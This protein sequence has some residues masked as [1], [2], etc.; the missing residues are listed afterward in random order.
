MLS[1]STTSVLVLGYCHNAL[2]MRNFQCI[3][4]IDPLN[5]EIYAYDSN[6]KKFL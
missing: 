4:T 1:L 6:A 3:V 5:A 2:E